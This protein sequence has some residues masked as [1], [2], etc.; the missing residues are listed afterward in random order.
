MVVVSL[1]Y[2]NLPHPATIFK[3]NEKTKL[4]WYNKMVAASLAYKNSL[5][6]KH[7]FAKAMELF[8]KRFIEMRWTVLIRVLLVEDSP[9]NT[10][11]DRSD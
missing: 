7:C 1:T 9:V 6:T 4:R 11:I 5:N 3:Q 10:L 2:K 8:P